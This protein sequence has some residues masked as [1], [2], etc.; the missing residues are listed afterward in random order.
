MFNKQ[1]RKSLNNII[2]IASFISVFSDKLKNI[3]SK[4]ILNY[5]CVHSNLFNITLF[6]KQSENMEERE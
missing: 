3:T 2:F 1:V 5:N 6:S 4:V